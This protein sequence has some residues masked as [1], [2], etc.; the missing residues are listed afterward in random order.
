MIK[1]ILYP[2]GEDNKHANK[3]WP[4]DINKIKQYKRIGGEEGTL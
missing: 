4:S 2:N 1:W 3:Q